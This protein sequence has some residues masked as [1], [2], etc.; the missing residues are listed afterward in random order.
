[1]MVPAAGVTACHQHPAVGQQ[2]RDMICTS[3]NWLTGCC[4]GARHRIV[5]FGARKSVTVAKTACDKHP[6]VGQE[7]RRVGR[8]R[9]Y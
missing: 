1:M 2:G 7:R 8:P 6:A 4:P 9:P 5:E 3:A